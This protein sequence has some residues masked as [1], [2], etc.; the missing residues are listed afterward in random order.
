MEKRRPRIGIDHHWATNLYQ[1]S[2][3]YEVTIPTCGEK[4]L[5]VKYGWLP[6]RLISSPFPSISAACL[7]YMY[8][9][10]ARYH[11]RQNN[12]NIPPI[13]AYQ[14]HRPPHSYYMENLPTHVYI[15]AL[16][17]STTSARPFQ[18]PE[19]PIQGQKRK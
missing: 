13:M 18:P 1:L 8:P 2:R 11:I 7:P 19:T 16:P 5:R 10:S 17:E 3:F 6:L 4:S 15:N 9:A 14:F 12:Q